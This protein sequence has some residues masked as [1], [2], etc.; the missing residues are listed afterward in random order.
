[1]L[2]TKDKE[3]ILEVLRIMIHYLQGTPVRIKADFSAETV[4]ARS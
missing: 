1:M 3:K 2:K 4:N